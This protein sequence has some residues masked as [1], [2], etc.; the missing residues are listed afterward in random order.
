MN[1][2]I[3]CIAA[4]G[5]FCPRA[6]AE[7]EFVWL[8]KPVLCGDTIDILK[9]MEDSGFKRVAKSTIV[10]DADE[11][12]VGQ[13]YYMIKEDDFAIIEIF[14]SKSC[15]IS[16]SKNFIMLNQIKKNNGI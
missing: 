12:V 14:N 4:L 3:L 13:M 6:F 7:D 11:S 2:I 9:N 8:S 10:K 16:I 15:I 5:L 1:K